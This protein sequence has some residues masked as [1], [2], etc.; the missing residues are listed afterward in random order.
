MRVEESLSKL[1]DFSIR[2]ELLYLP[3]LTLHQA[4]EIVAGFTYSCLSLYSNG[5]RFVL[6]G[7]VLA[8]TPPGGSVRIPKNF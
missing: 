4:A 1:G 5:T 3:A 2:V 7:C 6:V 8:L